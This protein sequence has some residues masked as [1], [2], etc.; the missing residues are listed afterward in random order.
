MRHF[1][2]CVPCVFADAQE[3]ARS[4]EAIFGETSAMTAVNVEE[5]FTALGKKYFEIQ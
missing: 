5:M 2:K 1:L 3:Y 4:I